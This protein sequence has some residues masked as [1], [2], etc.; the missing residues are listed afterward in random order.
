VAQHAYRASHGLRNIT[1]IQLDGGS[2]DIVPP[3]LTVI[4]AARIL[5]STND[6]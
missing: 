4:K 5:V 1:N 6:R 2:F 3:P